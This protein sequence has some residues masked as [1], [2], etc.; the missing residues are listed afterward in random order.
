MWFS[1]EPHFLQ[2]RLLNTDNKPC[3]ANGNE[4]VFAAGEVDTSASDSGY[5][6]PDEEDDNKASLKNRM[7]VEVKKCII[8][9]I[10]LWVRQNNL[11]VA[12]RM[13]KKGAKKA[14]VFKQ[15]WVV[16][17]AIPRGLR[18]FIK[19]KRLPVRIVSINKQSYTLISRF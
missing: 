19:L 6:Y 2:A 4:L 14:Q 9:A 17:L 16:T 3:D 10:E 18:L 8:N 15:G 12:A 11:L 1:R 5:P 13:V 7:A